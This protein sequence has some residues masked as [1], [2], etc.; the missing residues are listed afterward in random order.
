MTSAWNGDYHLNINLQE[1][2]W[3]V[4]STQVSEAFPPLL[5][6]LERMALAGRTAATR[7]YGSHKHSD[8]W[9]SH[10]FVDNYLSSG[11][12][13]DP[14]WSLCVTCGA[15]VVAQV[16]EHFTYSATTDFDLLLLR[17]MPVMRGALHFFLGTHTLYIYTDQ[18]V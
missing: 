16:W 2:Y 13:G 10:G 3:T 1:M 4:D 12:S 11:L 6:F 5:H 9:V 7:M 17:L 14:Q 18:T 8:S 15:W